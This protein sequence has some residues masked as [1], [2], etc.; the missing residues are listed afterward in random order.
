[1]SGTEQVLAARSTAT[2]RTRPPTWRVGARRAD[3]AWTIA[4]LVPYG[5]VFLAFAAYPTAYALWMGRELSLYAEL[6]DDPL[7][8][9]TL[10]NT[11]LFAG[12]GVNVMMFLALLLSG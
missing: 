12:V 3:L 7:Y 10:A 9:A 5:A 1:M 4:F 6:L 8:L 2:N 11:L